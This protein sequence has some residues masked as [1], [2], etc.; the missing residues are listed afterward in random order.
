[1]CED[2]Y[3]GRHL[4]NP[5]PSD[6]NSYEEM[7]CDQCVEVHQFLLSYHDELNQ[8][9]D[10][11]ELPSENQ[12]SAQQCCKLK[13]KTE[14]LETRKDLKKA[15]YWPPGWR[16][17]LCKCAS[18]LK[19]YN[20]QG[21]TFLI[22]DSDT[23]QAYEAQGQATRQKQGNDY[24]RGLEALASLNRVQQ[25]EA[26]SEFNSLQTELKDFL[27]KFAESRKVVRESDIREFFEELQSR[28]RQ[29]LEMPDLCR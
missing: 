29:R 15:S 2:W 24:E 18:C 21:V 11:T 6:A 9:S 27:S 7:I 23:V 3:H 25:V 1:M 16:A 17:Q 14:E 5:V 4:G 28:K 13:L 12:S 19:L 10:T 8:I 26:I 22:D 20:D